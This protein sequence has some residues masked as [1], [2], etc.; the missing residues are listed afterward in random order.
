MLS[1]HTR[2]LAL[3]AL[4]QRLNES[5]RALLVAR[6][7]QVHAAGLDDCT[8]YI[9]FGVGDTEFDLMAEIGMTPLVD[10]LGPR[11]ADASFE[12]WWDLLRHHDGWFELV[13]CVG[14]TGFAYVLFIEDAGTTD[15]ALLALCRHYADI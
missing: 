6:I 3:Q 1:L 4:D 14:D 11:F 8:H 2:E 5:L 7:G 12:P 15:A 13:I 9:V 10:P